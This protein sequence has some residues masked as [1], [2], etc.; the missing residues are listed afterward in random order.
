[1]SRTFAIG[2]AGTVLASFNVVPG[3]AVCRK[4]RR[5]RDQLGLQ[6]NLA[7]EK[8]MA[9][10]LDGRGSVSEGDA[11]KERLSAILFGRWS[12]ESQDGD[13]HDGCN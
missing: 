10:C 1:L 13:H 9:I 5:W 8:E 4:N 2:A 7:E 3:G 11:R 12:C 6:P